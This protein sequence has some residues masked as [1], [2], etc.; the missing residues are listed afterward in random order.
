MDVRLSL[1]ARNAIVDAV[2]A[3]IDAGAT[4]GVLRIYDG[5]RPASADTAVAGQALLAELTFASPAFSVAVDGTA[6]ANVI[7]ADASANAA[8]TATWSRVLDSDGTALL[9]L[10]VG[11]SGSGAALV[12][13]TT[14][15]TASLP[16]GVETLS[17]TAPES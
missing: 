11:E 5:A 1:A 2:A 13:N 10:D 7:T 14:E 8:G 16:V 12:L 17:L 9:D 6:T 15:I 3:A 4:G